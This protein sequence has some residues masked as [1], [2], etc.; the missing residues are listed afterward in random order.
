MKRALGILLFDDVELLDFCGPFEVF[1]VANNQCAGSAFDIFTVAERAPVHARNGLSVNPDHNLASCPQP[2]MLVVPGGIGSRK[3]LHNRPLID[4]IEGAAHGAELVLSVCTGALLLGKA[5][6]L[7]G[8]EM[9]THHVA[10]DLLREVVP[11]GTVH[12][13]RRFVDNGKFITSAGITAE[14]T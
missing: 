11:T 9:T 6:L 13:D 3:E 5:G 2:D 14:S 12:E 4:W 1:S 10:Y 8:L 7:D